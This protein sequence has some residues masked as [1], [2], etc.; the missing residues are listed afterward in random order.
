MDGETAVRED[1]VEALYCDKPAN[2]QRD[3]CATRVV[4]GL[5]CKCELQV[6]ER[7][8]VSSLPDQ[9]DGYAREAEQL[10]L[11]ANEVKR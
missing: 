6:A 2:L 7:Y 11:E 8:A 9:S 1:F 10:I 4:R 3:L 5:L